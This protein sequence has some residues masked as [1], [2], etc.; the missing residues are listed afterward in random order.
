MSV[1]LA[2]TREFNEGALRAILSSGQAVVLHRLA[3]MSKDGDWILRE[4]GTPWPTSWRCSIAAAPAIGTARRWTCA[5]CA[6]DGVRTSSSVPRPSESGPISS[7]GRP[8]ST[9]TTWRR[10][11]ANRRRAR[12]LSWTRAVSSSSRRRTARR[13]TRSS[14]NWRG[15]W[16]TRASSS[17][18]R[19]APGTSSRWSRRTPISRGNLPR[20]GRCWPRS[21]PGSTPWRRRSTPSAAR[22]IHANEQRLRRYLAA[23]AAWAARWPAVEAEIA[24]LPLSRAHEVVAARA[25]GVLPFEPPEA[26]GDHPA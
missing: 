2:L 25:E 4:S 6:G 9:R 1:Y 17:S 13:T 21:E 3:V 18:R 7:P 20:R 10:S 12:S 26:P 15:C 16:A 14:A 5:G 19:A 11:G 24:G 22:L 23:A 8:A